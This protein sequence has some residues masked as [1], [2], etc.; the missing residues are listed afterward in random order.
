[1][2]SLSL[3]VAAAREVESVSMSKRGSKMNRSKIVVWFGGGERITRVSFLRVL[4]AM[5]SLRPWRA[6]SM[7]ELRS[8]CLE[9]WTAR[10]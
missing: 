3:L 8:G 10:P 4:A 1:M 5:G 9:R 6:S 7:Y 2:V